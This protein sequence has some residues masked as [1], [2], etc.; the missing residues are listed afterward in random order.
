[1]KQVLYTPGNGGVCVVEVPAPQAAPGCVLVRT[2]ASLVSAGT[3]KTALEFARSSLAGKMQLRPDLV[4]QVLGKA[5]RDGLLTA[6]HAVRDRL[7]RPVALGYSSAGTILDVGG[8]VTDLQPGDRV[9]CAGAGYAAHA[10]IVSVPRNLVARILKPGP[11][12]VEPIDFEEAAFATLG[13]IA[14]HGLRLAEP[15]IGETVAIIGLGLVGLLAVQLARAAG[16]TVLGMDPD[17]TR[18]Q[19]AEKVGCA[20]CA[21]SEAEFASLVAARTESSGA[22]AVILAPATPSQRPVRLAGEVARRR[23]CVIAIGAVGTNVPRNL[24]YE[25]ELDFRISRSYGPGRYDREYEENGRDYPIEYV[26]WT[27][28][29]NLKAFLDLLAQARIDVRPLI[30]HRFAISEATRAYDLIL[31][32]TGEKHLAV[33]LTY[34]ERAV[35]SSRREL[36]LTPRNADGAGGARCPRVGVLG[37][38]NFALG[39]LVPTIRRTART[40]LVGVCAASGASA[41]YAAEKFGF[42]YSTTDSSQI[43][44]DPEID[45]VVIATPHS[46]HAPQVLAALAAGKTIFCEKPLC[47][48]ETELAEIVRAYASAEE[49]KPL[50][51][52]GF[53][54]RFSPMAKSLKETLAGRS[55][56]PLI[57]QYRV[58][59]GPAPSVGWMQDEGQG[60]RILGEVCHFVNLLMFLAGSAP[61]RVYARRPASSRSL[62]DDSA[63]I[64]LEFGDGS[65]G[66][67]A[68]AANG[69]PSFPKERLEVFGGGRIGVIEDFRRLELASNGG[70]RTAVWRLRQDKGHRTEWQEFLAA[71][72]NGK[73][74]IPFEEIVATTLTTLRILESLRRGRPLELRLQEFVAR[75]LESPGEERREHPA[76]AE[77]QPGGQH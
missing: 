37:A 61:V 28:N 25:K 47:I 39:V 20:A 1:M 54:R 77:V 41:Q 30:T 35:L 74:P 75:S 33:V 59:A 49:P 36:G 2:A 38:G 46:L 65:T 70:R 53:N 15:Q 52:V 23:G 34:S 69:E 45:T 29:R 13:A 17:R 22:D 67:I 31:G 66:T 73:P 21:A 50:L 8:G 24:Y 9:A 51:A 57:M 7:D 71:S 76:L 40:E 60:G 14:L 18:C 68:Y 6:F 26:R 5:R 32:Q 42:Q 27:E 19:I 64:F 63:L 12:R 58:N 11:Q 4:Q 55:G 44:E 62:R 43:L 10:E 16:C 72:Q 56:Q 3:E 48:S